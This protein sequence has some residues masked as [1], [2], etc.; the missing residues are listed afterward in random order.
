MRGGDRPVTGGAFVNRP[1]LKQDV[2]KH[3][4]DQILAGKIHP[5]DRIDQEAI[6]ADLGISRLPVREA[7][8][9]LEAEGMVDNV[10]RRGAYVAEL[11]RQD[12]VDHYEIYGLLSGLAAGRAATK[13]S[14]D[15]L[16]A[17][18]DVGVEMSAADDPREHDRLNFAFHQRIN[19]AGGSGR[20]I[21]VIRMLSNSMP[22]H[23]FEHNVNPTWKERS[24][25]EHKLIVSALRARDSALASET[26]VQHFRHTAEDAVRALESVGFWENSDT[27]IATDRFERARRDVRGGR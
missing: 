21:A 12:I 27:E 11:S 24:T 16:R 9:L 4:R 17:L 6:A 26:M 23:F 25:S 22:T 20:L 1:N 3:I 2:A 10:A 15:S 18:D 7:L 13:I 19:K 14:E 8:I 5:S